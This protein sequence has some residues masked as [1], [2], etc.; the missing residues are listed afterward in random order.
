MASKKTSPAL[1]TVS[2]A[3][4]PAE[5]RKVKEAAEEDRRSV[6]NWLR[7]LILKAL[8]KK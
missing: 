6:S 5:A 1:V 2:A 7:G 4:S 8:E 3:L